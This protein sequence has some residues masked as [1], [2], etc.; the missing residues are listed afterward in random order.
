MPLLEIEQKFSFNAANLARLLRNPTFSNPQKSAFHDTYFDSGNRLSNAG[1]WLRK[2]RRLDPKPSSFLFSPSF[3]TSTGIANGEE[4]WEAKRSVRNGSF[5]RS[6]F[7]E[8]K[9]LTQIRQLLRCHFPHPDDR[10]NIQD[11]NFGLNPIAAFGTER[12][13][14]VAKEEEDDDREFSVVLDSTDFGHEVG[15]V[16][17]IAEEAEAEKAHG[18]IERFLKRYPWFFDTRGPKGKLTAYF[19]RFGY[20]EGEEKKGWRKTRGSEM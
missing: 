12:V 18:D 17:V 1:L 16:E 8:T 14:L 15:E 7:V 6:T 13:T 4:E 2:R 9:D 3:H 19:E 10:S 20:P 5:L 11:D